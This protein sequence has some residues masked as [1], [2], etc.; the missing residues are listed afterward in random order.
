MPRCVLLGVVPVEGGAGV[1]VGVGLLGFQVGVGV[2]A[3]AVRAVGEREGRLFASPQNATRAQRNPARLKITRI[4]GS[5]RHV[6]RAVRLFSGVLVLVEV[7]GRHQARRAASAFAVTLIQRWHNR[8][9]AC[10]RLD[11]HVT[12]LLSPK[13]VCPHTHAHTLLTP[14]ERGPAGGGHHLRRPAQYQ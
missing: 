7:S 4:S 11:P 1:G 8:N 12:Q 3:L 13:I 6:S 5:R 2:V 14:T 10:H 9:P